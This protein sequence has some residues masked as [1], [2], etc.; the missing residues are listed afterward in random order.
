MMKGRGIGRFIKNVV[1]CEPRS[2]SIVQNWIGNVRA[3]ALL[4]PTFGKFS[5]P[6]T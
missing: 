4:P 3:H 2:R 5:I 6:G 1:G